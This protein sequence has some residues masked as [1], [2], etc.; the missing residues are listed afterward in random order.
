MN[1]LSSF[2]ESYD[3]Y[4]P[5]PSSLDQIDKSTTETPG[6]STISGDSFAYCRTNS[7]TSAFSEPTDDQ[8]YSSEPSPSCW[9]A[10]KSLNSGAGVNNHSVLTKLGMKQH[11][12]RVGDHKLNDQE[13]L[14]SGEF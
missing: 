2:E 6:Y 14:D 3:L 11:K 12:S 8:S 5:S 4:Q 10:L 1:N 13:V 7:E 9:H